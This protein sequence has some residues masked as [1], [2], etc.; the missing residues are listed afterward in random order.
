MTDTTPSK[1]AFRRPLAALSR[2]F[3]RPSAW[4]GALTVLLGLFAC[5]LGSTPDTNRTFDFP[6]LKGKIGEADHVVITLK[7]SSGKL[8]DVLFDGP[9][10]ANTRFEDL[11]AANY[12]GGKVYIH[13]EATK[14]GATVYKVQRGYD[15]ARGGDIAAETTVLVDPSKIP[16]DTTPVVT[17][18]QDTATTPRL[19]L[20]PD[21]LLL[22]VRGPVG[23]F[24]VAFLPDTSAGPVTWSTLDAGVE[25]T[26]GGQVTAKAQGLSRVV[27]AFQ[28]HASAKDTAFVQVLPVQG[29]DSIRFEKEAT[30][31]LVQGP[32]DSLRLRVY[33][34]LAPQGV[35]Y[36]V[37]DTAVVRLVG[38]A[39][40]GL[41][42][43]KTH[44]YAHSSED[45]TKRDSLAV[46]V[47]SPKPADSLRIEQDTVKLF[48]KGPGQTLTALIYPAESGAALPLDE[49]GPRHRHGKCTGNGYPRLARPDPGGSQVLV[50][51][52]EGRP[53]CGP[54]E[55]RHSPHPRRQRHHSRQGRDPGP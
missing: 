20:Q 30:N 25:V 5:Q 54:G 19:I 28:A 52:H 37:R 45:P 16:P 13:I 22:A 12:S 42:E 49:P 32:L 55:E 26:A 24:T 40:L 36:T 23:R 15:P 39:L 27:A 8:I 9:V 48:V 38:G 33:P 14:D 3:V 41:R 2:A 31:L 51:Q 43:G 7:D 53:R 29:V 17:P 46:V 21:T 44:V 11:T 4:I 6:T 35:V 47:L 18:P 50:R 34:P 10:D 1:D